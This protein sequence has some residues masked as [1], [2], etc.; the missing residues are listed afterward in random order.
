MRARNSNNS[1]KFLLI[2]YY[3]LPL[4]ICWWKVRKKNVIFVP[5][6]NA[7]RL[8][9]AVLHLSVKRQTPKMGRYSQRDK[10]S[11][12]LYLLRKK[13]FGISC[14]Q[15][16]NKDLPVPCSCRKFMAHKGC[17]VTCHRS[18]VVDSLWPTHLDHYSE[19]MICCVKET[20]KH[21]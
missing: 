17:H 5:A 7:T 15:R 10:I 6:L 8:L 20:N 11:T 13:Q 1:P 9:Q 18:S 14:R 16:Q 21:K 2:F 3:L 12:T 19:P 4:N